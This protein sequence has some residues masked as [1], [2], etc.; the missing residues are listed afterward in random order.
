M[1]TFFNVHELALRYPHSSFLLFSGEKCCFMLIFLV[2]LKLPLIVGHPVVC[3]VSQ[4]FFLLSSSVF[5]FCFSIFSSQYYN[6]HLCFL[7]PAIFL[8]TG[9]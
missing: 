8:S 1:S 2:K 7:F 4:G 5:S 9:M 3:K 6:K